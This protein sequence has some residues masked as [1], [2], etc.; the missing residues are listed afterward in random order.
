MTTAH[1]VILSIGGAF[2]Q[3]HQWPRSGTSGLI[4]AEKEG[5]ENTGIGSHRGR[6]KSWI[7]VW[8][9]VSTRIKRITQG[10]AD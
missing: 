4:Q 2:A 7:R 1:S 5:K 8:L 9:L 3:P 10:I 6:I